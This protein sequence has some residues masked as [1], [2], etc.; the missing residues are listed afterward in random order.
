DLKLQFGNLGLAAAAYNAGGGRVVQWL[1][2]QSDLPEE[3]RLYVA[4]VTGRAVEQWGDPG[5]TRELSGA[6][7]E[8]CLA[9]MADPVR[10]MPAR[11]VAPS[12]V[13]EL[14]RN[15]ARSID[16]HSNPW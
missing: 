10:P 14:D 5:G 1:R 3:T 9:L 13:L 11:T 7:G 2:R 6:D 15:L 12:W 4:A 16:F 8:P